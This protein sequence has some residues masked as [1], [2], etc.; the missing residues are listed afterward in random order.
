MMMLMMITGRRVLSGYV[1]ISHWKEIALP[2]TMQ[3]KKE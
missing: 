3:R 2:A 1:K